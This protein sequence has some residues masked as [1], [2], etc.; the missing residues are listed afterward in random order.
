MAY[1]PQKTRQYMDARRAERAAHAHRVVQRHLDWA[2][3]NP[4]M[5][6]YHREMAVKAAAK[7]EELSRPRK[8]PGIHPPTGRNAAV[9]EGRAAGRSLQE[10]GDQFG[11]TREWVRQ[12][13]ERHDRHAGTQINQDAKASVYRER[14]LRK[15]KRVERTCLC[16]AVMMTFPSSPLTYCSRRCSA[17]G[18]RRHLIESGRLKYDDDRVI[19]IID[20]RFAGKNW[21]QITQMMGLPGTHGVALQRAVYAY[22]IRENQL[23]HENV[24]VLYSTSVSGIVPPWLLRIAAPSASG[25]PLYGEPRRRKIDNSALD[26]EGAHT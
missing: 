20:L 26:A 9:I 19:G 12:I 8:R 15:I 18:R 21:L 25:Q 17:I 3:E 16:G 23:T 22:L 14:G 24:R 4:G 10:I 13:V 7:A 1:I 11:I 5:A 2:A 6:D